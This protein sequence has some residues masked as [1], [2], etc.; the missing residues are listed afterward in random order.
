MCKECDVFMGNIEEV[1]SI[2]EIKNGKGCR[3]EE[4][5]VL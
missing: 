2:M 1:D 4:V 5:I 3:M